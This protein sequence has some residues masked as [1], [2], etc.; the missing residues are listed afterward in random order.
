MSRMDFLVEGL[1]ALEAAG[2]RRVPRVIEAR[3][4]PRVRVDGRWLI[5][6]SSNDYLGLA[7]HPALAAAA[8]A[9][10]GEDGVGAGASRLIT[11]NLARAEALE[12]ALAAFHGAPAARLFG[13][14]YAANTGTIPVLVGKDDLI[15]S[16]ELNHASV[17]D[18]CR[19]SRATV[20]IARHG[21]A[22]HVD[23][24]LRQGSG[25]RRLVITESL[26]SM[27]GDVAPLAELREVSQ[28]HGAMLM[29]DDAHA[30]GVAHEG[31]GYGVASGADV[32]VGTLGKAFGA[33]GA[34]VLGPPALAE[35]LWT[36]ARSLV[37]ST[38]VAVPVLA[39]A[40]EAVRLVQGEEG[41]RRRRRL[42]ELVARVGGASHIIPILVGDDRRV[43]EMMER[44][45]EVGVLL[46][47]IRPPTVPEGTAR[48]RMSLSASLGEED[49]GR[50]LEALELLRRAG[51]DVPRGTS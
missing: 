37:F 8:A 48:L 17:I 16:D 32:V 5:N 7:T 27:D 44:V 15:V 3:Q 23:A 43:M 11:G 2:R 30:V 25:R 34:Y 24:L 42:A 41:R 20:R 31:A 22:E 21:D 28:R 26:F 4:G 33:A 47:A 49:V 12:R 51:F 50:V 36:R 9:S 46:Q 1:E 40:I 13:S 6:V 38:G 14:G 45:K 18:G 39:A 19:L 10:V 35:L 29:V